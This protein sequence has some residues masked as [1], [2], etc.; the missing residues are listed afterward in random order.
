MQPSHPLKRFVSTLICSRSPPF[1]FN[2]STT[3]AC[4]ATRD[5]IDVYRRL[6]GGKAWMQREHHPPFPRGQEV[7]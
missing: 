5:R 2:E 4:F 6:F 7:G 3:I 1:A